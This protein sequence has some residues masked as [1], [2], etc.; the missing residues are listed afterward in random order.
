MF[1]GKAALKSKTT[2]KIKSVSYLKS[3]RVSEFLY[4]KIGAEAEVS[5]HENPSEVFEETKKFV[6]EL[7]KKTYPHITP[8]S[9]ITIP[10]SLPEIQ[11]EKQVS[12]RTQMFIQDINACDNKKD[13][14]TYHKIARL[15]PELQTAYDKKFKS[16][17]I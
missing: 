6:E 7:G 5:E 17:S 11:I 10:Q 15:N 8:E 9:Q 3:F 13:L 4:D 14:E 12:D 1:Y 2:M 16:L